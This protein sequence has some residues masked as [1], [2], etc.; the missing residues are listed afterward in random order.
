MKNR[1]LL[2]I[3]A[4]VVLSGSAMADFEAVRAG[5]TGV[6]GSV[7]ILD[8]GL[9]G[10]VGGGDDSSITTYAGHFGFNYSD[11]GASSNERGG[12]QFKS[13][14]FD[15]FCI[16]LQDR[17]G[18]NVVYD[19][20]QIRNAPNP[21][22]GANQPAY[23][24]TD[25]HEVHRVVSAAISLGWINDDL[26]A[27]SASNGQLAAIQAH[28]WAVVLDNAIVTAEAGISAHFST[29]ATEIGMTSTGSRVAGL[30]AMIADGSQ[31]Q[32]Y[33][34]PL[35]TA[36]FAGLITLGGLAGIKRIRRA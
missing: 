16:E 2:S 25:E 17:T 18:G 11:T 12:G 27:A 31:D 13:G 23:D 15:T 22:G 24:L 20:D 14:H 7:T 6:G 19:V 26:S 30:R 21:E 28:I 36:A 33:I 9:D 4:I 5:T 10:M 8:L 35:P 32:L 1:A 3:G 29:L 34:V